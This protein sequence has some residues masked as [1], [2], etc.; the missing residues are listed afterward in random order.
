MRNDEA[1]LGLVGMLFLVATLAFIFGMWLGERNMQNQATKNGAA[2]WKAGAGGE[3]TF[4]WK[5]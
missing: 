3:A 5:E 4:H 2:E 1:A